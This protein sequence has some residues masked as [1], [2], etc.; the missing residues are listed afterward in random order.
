MPS[1]VEGGV[2]V[3]GPDVVE[4]KDYSEYKW[5]HS[6]HLCGRPIKD[7][8]LHICEGCNLP[9]LIYGRMVSPYSMLLACI[10]P[11]DITF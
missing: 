2:G 5:N 1:S 7:P 9:I 8:L 4:F 3:G 11:N 6:V 10:G